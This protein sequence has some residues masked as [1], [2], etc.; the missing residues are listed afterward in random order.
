MIGRELTD[1]Q[2]QSLKE[3]R[4]YAEQQSELN[5]QHEI[6][7]RELDLD[8]ERYRIQ[9]ERLWLKQLLLTPI[10]VLLILPLTVAVIRKHKVEEILGSFK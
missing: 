6:K 5:R 1:Q 7:I 9:K 4:E 8:L 3:E 2:A 10:K